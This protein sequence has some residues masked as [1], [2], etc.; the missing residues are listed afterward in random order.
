MNKRDNSDVTYSDMLA[1][2]TEASFASSPTDCGFFQNGG[3]EL[4]A[5]GILVGILAYFG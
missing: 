4:E 1:V 5:L 2:I 3:A